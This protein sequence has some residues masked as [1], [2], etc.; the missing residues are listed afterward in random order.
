MKDIRDKITSVIKS[1]KVAVGYKK[2]IEALL[3]NEP[4]AIVASAR[5]PFETLNNLKYYTMMLGIP[6][7]LVDVDS[8]ELGSL[9]NRRYPVSVLAVLESDSFGI[10]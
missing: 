7:R 9:C 2:S 8:L 4:K 1:G 5:L 6:L 10:I 3:S